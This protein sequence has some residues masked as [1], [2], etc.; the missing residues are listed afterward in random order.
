MTNKVM[1]PAFHVFG[2]L[3]IAASFAITGCSSTDNGDAGGGVDATPTD[4]GG[5]GTPDGGGVKDSGGPADTGGGGGATTFV[6]ILEGGQEVP[7]TTSKAIGGAVF[8]LNGTMLSYHLV[9]NVMGASAAHIHMAA[10]GASGAVVFPLTLSGADSSGMIA[11]ALTTDQI[12]GLSSGAFYV[13]VHSAAN[14]NGEIRGQI[15]AGAIYKASLSGAMESPTTTSTATGVA[16]FTVN[17]GTMSYHVAHNVNGATAS[18]L[19][20]AAA[21][22]AGPVIHALMITDATDIAGTGL[23]LMGT[24]VADIKAGDVYVNI[25]SAADPNGEIRGQ[26]GPLNP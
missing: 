14:P 10:A 18:H 8:T 5:G 19:H 2:A 21:G 1:L 24:D 11:T 6:A 17:N 22:M 23:A 7:A 3:A 13:N 12:A 4:T 16:Y 15:G 9:Q 26:L 20:K 25:H